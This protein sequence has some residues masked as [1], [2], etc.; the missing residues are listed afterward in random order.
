MLNCRI[1]Q[2]IRKTCEVHNS[3]IYDTIY[4]YDM[5]DVMGL[6]FTNDTRFDN[7]NTIS[8][9]NSASQFYKWEVSDGEYSEDVDSDTY[10][11]ELTFN[12]HK[13][14]EIEDILSDAKNSKFLVA[15]RLKSETVYR[16]I[17]WDLGAQ[18]TYTL[19]AGEDGN[20]YTITFT[21]EGLYPAFECDSQNFDEERKTYTPIW[22]PN[23]N[24]STCETDSSGTVTGYRIASYVTKQ[25]TAGEALDKNNRLCEYSGLPQDAYKLQGLSDGGYNIVGTYTKTQTFNGEA[26]IKYD[27]IHC[28]DSSTGTIS[29]SPTTIT[30][31]EHYSPSQTITIT[32]NDTWS[33]VNNSNILDVSANSGRGNSSVTAT[34]NGVSTAQQGQIAVHN[35]NTN[36]TVYITTKFFS[37]NVSGTTLIPSTSSSVTGYVSVV[38]GSSSDYK[39]NVTCNDPTVKYTVTK[40]DGQ[41]KINIDPTTVGANGAVYTVTVTHPTQPNET[42][43]YKITQQGDKTQPIWTLIS[44]YCESK[45]GVRTGNLVKRYKDTNPNSSTYMQTKDDIAPS[46]QCGKAAEEW[47]VISTICLTDT[48]GRNTGVKRVTEMQITEGYDTYGTTRTTDIV[49]YAECPLPSAEPIWETVSTTCLTDNYGQTGVKEITQQD[50]NPDSATYKTTR[51]VTETDEKTCV[52]DTNAYWTTQSTECLQ[53]AGQNTGYE[54]ITYI[55][56]NPRSS[57]SGNTKTETVYNTTDC[58]L[59][60]SPIWETQSYECVLDD[61]GD[62]TGEVKLTQMDTN[63]NSATYKTTRTITETDTTKC[64]LPST[65]PKWVT[66]SYTCE[67]DKSGLNTG[68]CT[69]VQKDENKKSSTYGTER[70]IT[71]KDTTLCPISSDTDPQWEVTSITCETDAYGQTGNKITIYSDVNE[72]SATYKKMKTE[73]TYDSTTCVPNTDPYWV[74]ESSECETTDE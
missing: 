65:E 69:K 32:T 30:V 18:L 49:D 29:V 64:P 43:T 48:D 70:T 42:Y 40:E 67:V 58:P 20:Y 25:N 6:T 38:G 19:T 1:S 28:G 56:A 52:P 26:V 47:I 16:V 5:D 54:K 45:D 36:E 23:F 3:G 2:N 27:S 50:T 21:D 71:E 9:I 74:T 34:W 37:V 13:T 17:G 66:Q 51:V 10:S 14:E 22:R 8:A 41:F 61:N 63:P 53:N 24:I 12:I 57:T 73:I 68:Q 59:S 62:N 4:L 15:F 72:K 33:I 55:D 31:L 39:V 46:T 7:G 11:H 44:Q 35:E 60:T